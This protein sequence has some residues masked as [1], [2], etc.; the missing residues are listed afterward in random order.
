MRAHTSN[1][2]YKDNH[3]FH[4]QLNIRAALMAFYLGTGG[5]DIGDMACFLE[6]PGGR[7]WERTFHRH[8][9]KIHT[10]IM[11][12]TERILADAFEEEVTATI[13]GKP[14]DEYTSEEIEK[15][16]TKFKNKQ[17]DK[18][19]EEIQRIGIAISYDMG[20]NKRSTGRVYDSLSGHG[21]IIGCLT[22]KVI[23]YGVRKK[24]CSVCKNLNSCSY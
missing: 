8:S 5:Y 15:F 7:A 11:S 21:F 12:A 22:G 17:I 23:G 1:N 13:R 19:P 20:W 4:Y 24:K 3:A 16:V 14:K 18:L 6:I 2:L 10:T 9:T